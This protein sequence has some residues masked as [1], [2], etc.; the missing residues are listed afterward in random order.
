MYLAATTKPY[1]H[2]EYTGIWQEHSRC[3]ISSFCCKVP[4]VQSRTRSRLSW[5]ILWPGNA[6]SFFAHSSGIFHQNICVSP[7][8]PPCSTR[9]VLLCQREIRVSPAAADIVLPLCLRLCVHMRTCPKW[10]PSSPLRSQQFYGLCHFSRFSELPSD[11]VWVTPHPVTGVCHLFRLSAL[12]S[13]NELSPQ[14]QKFCRCCH[15]QVIWTM[16]WTM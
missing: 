16:H 5:Q 10:N 3:A 9:R 4:F 13:D 1:K 15:F 14:Q 12:P 11:N 7:Q 8:S 2:R 6:D